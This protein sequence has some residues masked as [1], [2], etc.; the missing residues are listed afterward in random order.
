[1]LVQEPSTALFEGIPASVI[2]NNSPQ[3]LAPR[4]LANALYDYILG[5]NLPNTILDYRI[6]SMLYSKD[7]LEEMITA[8]VNH[9]VDSL[10]ANPGIPVFVLNELSYNPARITQLFA[11][12]EKIN[13]DYFKEQVEKKTQGKT[14]A[15]AG[16]WAIRA[17]IKAVRKG[18]K[19]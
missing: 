11:G 3:I 15:E 5:H 9:T 1:V 7:L 12:K 10:T 16:I 6:I 18:M 4:K 14:D 19:P 2:L 8:Y 13:L 17:M